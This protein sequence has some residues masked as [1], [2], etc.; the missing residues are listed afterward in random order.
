MDIH[1]APKLIDSVSYGGFQREKG[2]WLKAW[3]DDVIK[4]LSEMILAL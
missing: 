2:K 4:I 3:T 1:K